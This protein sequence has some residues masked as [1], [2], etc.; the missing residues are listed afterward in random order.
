MDSFFDHCI[1][2]TTERLAGPVL[3]E[4]SASASLVS[5]CLQSGTHLAW[6]SLRWHVLLGV[7]VE[8]ETKLEFLRCLYA[9][10]K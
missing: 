6:H 10:P 1:R 7:L 2:A 4:R 5:V 3:R 8:E 9:R